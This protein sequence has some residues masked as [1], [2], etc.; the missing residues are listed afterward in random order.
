LL[1]YRE[2]VGDFRRAATARCLRYTM[3][4][5]LLEALGGVAREI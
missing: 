3:T 1:I 2:L 4:A 5:L